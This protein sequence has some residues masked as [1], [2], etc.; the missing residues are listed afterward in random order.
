FGAAYLAARLL[1]SSTREAT[2][3]GHRLAG[4]VVR[5]H[6]ALIR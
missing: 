5:H 4:E 6:G 2:E 1:G 3:A